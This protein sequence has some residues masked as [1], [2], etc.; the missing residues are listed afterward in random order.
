M[1]E[2]RSQGLPIGS[3][4]AR[5]RRIRH[6]RWFATLNGD[7]TGGR[8]GISPSPRFRNACAVRK[9]LRGLPNTP[10]FQSD[11]RTAASERNLAMSE[12]L[13]KVRKALL[14]GMFTLTAMT[15]VA[16]WAVAATQHSSHYTGP[17]PVGTCN[18]GN[19]T[20]LCEWTLRVIGPGTGSVVGTDTFYRQS[21]GQTI[22]SLSGDKTLSVGAGTFN[23]TAFDSEF[24]FLEST[25]YV[26][27]WTRGCTV[28]TPGQSHSEGGAS[29]LHVVE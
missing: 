16:L 10:S 7:S 18:E 26:H 23:I 28:Q 15:F 2:S 24:R 19:Y 8:C 1:K 3:E 25:F 29:S 9:S 6:F 20:V 13:A 17:A 14:P 5:S 4:A 21:D 11:D 12:F 22:A 27:S